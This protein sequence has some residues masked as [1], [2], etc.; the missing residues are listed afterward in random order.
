MLTMIVAALV[1]HGADPFGRKE[2]ALLYL[3]FYIT[4]FIVGSRKY[5]IDYLLTGKSTDS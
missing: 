2:M 4:L 5:S 1:T 3:L